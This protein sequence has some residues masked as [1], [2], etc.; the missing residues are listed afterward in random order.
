MS[1][2]ST[3]I[4][5]KIF[6]LREDLRNSELNEFDIEIEILKDEIYELESELDRL[7]NE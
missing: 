3:D 6:K 2:Y 5:N 1:L 4:E 7:E